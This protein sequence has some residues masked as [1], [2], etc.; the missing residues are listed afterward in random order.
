MRWLRNQLGDLAF[1]RGTLLRLGLNARRYLEP[2][3]AGGVSL[4]ADVGGA[5]AGS[6]SGAD[7]G[8]GDLF[9]ACIA[10]HGTGAAPDAGGGEGA[11]VYLSPFAVML[12][13]GPLL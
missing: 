10:D 6:S 4:P 9:G 1:R 11:S 7:I 3:V 8:A 5:L 13:S 2:W 12:L